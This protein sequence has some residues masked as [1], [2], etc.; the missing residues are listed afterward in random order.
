M[1]TGALIFAH[2]NSAVD[3]VKLATFSA[4]R[5]RQ[6]LDIPVSIVTDD[7][8]WLLENHPDHPFD[9][10]IESPGEFATTKFF[11][12]GSLASK[13]L[14][15]KNLSRCQ[16]YEL[17]PYDKTLVIDSDYIINSSILKLALD[18]NDVF[19]I[20]Q[21]S[22]DVAGWRD[23][24]C[25]E[26][27][28]PYSI[29]FYWATVFIFEK[30]EITRAL[31]DLVAYIKQNY[32]YFRIL[33]NIDAILYRNDFAFSIAIHIMNGKTNG[34][35]VTELPGTMMYIR[36]RDVLIG[37]DN[38]KMQLLVEKENHLG[39]YIAAKTEGVDLHVMNKISLSRIIDEVCNV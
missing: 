28:N 13:E 17:T 12:D 5:I 9:Q 10:I 6:Y 37:M 14:E 36:D 15:W 33:Y 7:V 4:Q 34:K 25:F 38:N 2:N 21:K 31:F 18:R 8:D 20:Y 26:R 39:E 29:P 22:Y 1:S 35:F 19:Q 3:Y 24:T 27:L 30:N 32:R 11:Y 16:A 23:Q